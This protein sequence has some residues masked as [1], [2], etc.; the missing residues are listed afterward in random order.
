MSL[1]AK[2]FMSNAIYA[3]SKVPFSSKTSAVTAKGVSW[4]LSAI[5]YQT[6]GLTNAFELFRGVAGYHMLGIKGALFAFAD[7]SGCQ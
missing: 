2:L 4:I 7:A 1:K 3:P 6:S 5:V